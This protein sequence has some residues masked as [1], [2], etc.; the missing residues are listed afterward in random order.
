MKREKEVTKRCL[1]ESQVKRR[2]GASELKFSI[3]AKL[4]RHSRVEND[5]RFFRQILQHL[6]DFAAQ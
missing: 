4:T 1:K 2:E 3:F 5:L 6:R